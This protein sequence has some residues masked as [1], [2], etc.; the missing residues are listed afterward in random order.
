MQLWYLR[1]TSLARM[2]LFNQASAECSN[3]WTVLGNIQPERAR[4]RLFD[5]SLPHELQLIHARIKYWAGDTYGY[6]DELTML[7]NI[8]KRKARSSI[9]SEDRETWKER[10]A[11]TGMVMASQL[12]EMQVQK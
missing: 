7:L 2:R 5:L 10:G 8:C 11:R 6:L 12:L 1:L 3:L 4:I 9:S